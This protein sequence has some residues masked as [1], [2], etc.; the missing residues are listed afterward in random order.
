MSSGA[1]YW[2]EMNALRI[3]GLDTSGKTASAAILDTRQ[4][5]LL[6]E[7]TVYTTRTHSQVIMP[8]AM[9]LLE[10]C[11][12]QI[13]D[14]DCFA[15]AVGPGSYTGLR[16]GIA[17]VQGMAMV[18]NTPCIGVSTLESLASRVFG[19]PD[20]LAVMHARSDLFYAAWFSCQ[21]GSIRRMTPDLL[22]TAGEIAQAA[23]CVTGQ[24]LLVGDGAEEFVQQ[25]Q[26][27][28]EHR[29][30][31]LRIVPP[32]LRLQSAAGICQSAAQ[33]CDGRT[34]L[35]TAADLT[36]SYLQAVQIQKKRN[37]R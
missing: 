4:N 18:N 20:I 16:I 31:D 36:A 15:V 19:A 25:Y 33:Y 35:P 23:D 28:P 22:Q 32:P 11:R 17:A 14:V 12:M 26:A 8:M 10:E 29:D 37:D 34:A 5:A 1:L 13:A 2:K 3:L 24:I 21:D 6:G 30:A 9:A 7:H 27:L